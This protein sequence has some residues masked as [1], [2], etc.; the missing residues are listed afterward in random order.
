MFLESVEFDL[1]HIRVFRSHF[2]IQ[3]IGNLSLNQ[4]FE[5][6]FIMYF[7]FSYLYFC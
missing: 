5:K 3:L 1:K 7:C 4:Y 6:C 2:V